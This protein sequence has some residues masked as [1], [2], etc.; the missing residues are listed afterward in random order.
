MP[1]KPFHFSMK[2]PATTL[3]RTKQN[4]KSGEIEV[5]GDQWPMFLYAKYA[6]D[7]EDPW[8][9]LLRS[10]ILIFVRTLSVVVFLLSSISFNRGSN[11]Y[12]PL[13]VP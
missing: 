4:L 13:Q 10:D 6:Y 3:F 11:M 1:S 7:P 5:R 12:L 2:I 8:Q 9:G